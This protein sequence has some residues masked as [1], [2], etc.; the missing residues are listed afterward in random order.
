MGRSTSRVAVDRAKSTLPRVRTW[1]HN[2]Y[3]EVADGLRA[4]LPYIPVLPGRL[5]L[6]GR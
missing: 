1:A 5:P 6:P 3:P 4:E 2:G